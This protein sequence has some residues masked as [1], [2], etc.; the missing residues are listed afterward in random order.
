MGRTTVVRLVSRV[1]PTGVARV[2]GHG[3]HGLWRPLG[4][5]VRVFGRDVAFD[6][7]CVPSAK[8]SL[9]PSLPEFAVRDGA[10]LARLERRTLRA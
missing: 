1:E 4:R 2:H 10:R 7:L 6:R 3:A 5:L 8:V 9:D